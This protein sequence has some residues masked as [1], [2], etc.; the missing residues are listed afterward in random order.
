METGY[1]RVADKSEI[2][3]GQMKKVVV[4]EVGILIVNLEGHFYAVGSECTHFGGDLSQGVFEGNV[5]TCPNHQ[6]KFDVTSGVVVSPP[7]EPL[8][9]P[10]IE[11]L[12]SYAVKIEETSILVKL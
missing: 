9:R 3:V 6:A 4:G 8:G 1:V 7:I 2:E 5:V 12:P 10:E 11:N